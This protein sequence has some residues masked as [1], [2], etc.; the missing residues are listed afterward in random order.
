MCIVSN[1]IKENKSLKSTLLIIQEHDIK[2][3]DT[4]VPEF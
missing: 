4:E 3:I 2:S 1:V